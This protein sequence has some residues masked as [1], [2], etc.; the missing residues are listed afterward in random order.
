MGQR[1]LLP[2]AAEVILDQLQVQ[3]RERIIMVL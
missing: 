2:E 3:G 1:T